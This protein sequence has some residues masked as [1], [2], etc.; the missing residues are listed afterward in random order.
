MEAIFLVCGAGGP[1]L[2]RN[3]LG[4]R[5]FV[6]RSTLTPEE[7]TP[8]LRP[9]WYYLGPLSAI[10]ALTAVFSTGYILS[11]FPTSRNPGQ[12]WL[13]LLIWL[14]IWGGVGITI[15]RQIGT[16]MSSEGIR[17]RGL[18][19]EKNIRWQDVVRVTSWKAGIRIASSHTWITFIPEF[20]QHQESVLHFMR[21]QLRKQAPHFRDS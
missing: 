20:C 7:K 11:D 9:N 15:V 4:S 5:T 13:F 19:G 10:L 3:P 21:E 1:Q 14:A 6:W 2:K 12:S 8:T 18:L 16:S 17:Q